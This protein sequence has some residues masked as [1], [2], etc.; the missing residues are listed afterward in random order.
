MPEIVGR[1]AE[2]AALTGFVDAVGKGPCALVFAGE[3]GIGKTT[4]WSAGVALAQERSFQVLSCRSAE[5]EAKLSYAGLGDVLAEVA[6][7][8]LG[9]LPDLQRHAVEVALLRT[10]PGE[11]PVD[12]RTVAAGTLGALRLLA[13]T[14]PVVM[15]LD[16]PQWMDAAS[17]QALKYAVRRLDDEP[18]GVLAAVR[19]GQGLDDPLEISR[20]FSD[21]RLQQLEIG[22]LSLEALERMLDQRLGWV[23]TGSALFELHTVSEGNPLFALE[24]ARA[25]M[26]Q[27]ERSLVV[28][29]SLREQASG[30]LAALPAGTRE[31]LVVAAALPRPTLGMI[32]QVIG[33]DR[34]ALEPAAEAGMLEVQGDTVRFTH[35]L[36]ASVAYA[37]AGKGDRVRIHRRLSELLTDPEERARHLAL[38][39]DPPDV[40]VA[41]ALEEAANRAR[42]RGA[43]MV[44]AALRMEARTFTPEDRADDGR[45]RAVLAA[46]DLYVVGD[47]TRTKVLLE[48]ALAECPDGS[49]RARVLWRLGRL[50]CWGDVMSLDATDEWLDLAE[51]H[52]GDDP[53]L[54]SQIHR[55]RCF[56]AWQRVRYSE[57]PEHARV[58]LEMAERAGDPVGIAASLAM[59]AAAEATTGRAVVDDLIVRA[60]EAWAEAARAPRDSVIVSEDHPALMCGT[61]YLWTGRLDEARSMFQILE[62]DSRERGSEVGLC[63]ALS[64]LF[65]VELLAGNWELAARYVD[66]ELRQAKYVNEIEAVLSR[67]SLSAHLGR[68]D[69]ARRDLMRVL[70]YNET[71]GSIDVL[72]EVLSRLGFLELSLGNLA[73]THGYLSRATEVFMEAGICEPGVV[74]EVHF[75]PDEIEALVGLGE[76]AEAERLIDWLEERG[77]ALDRVWALAVGSRCRG[78]LFAAKGD[79]E[80]AVEHIERAMAEHERLPMPFERARTLLVL[81]SVRRRADH[82]RAAREALTEALEVFERLGAVLW[83]E[84]ARAELAAIGGRAPGIG[85]FT[86]MEERVARLAAAGRTNREIAETLFLSVRTVEHH[87]SH[88]YAKRGV[89]S[90]TEL[91]LV[92]DD[93]SVPTP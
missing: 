73:A 31:T 80:V 49:E 39:V 92:L 41:A 46:D 76:L 81:G 43:P 54:S 90:R 4:L 78:L 66:E 40:G 64:W 37:D 55:M 47:H 51:E 33:R 42:S 48:Q 3:P 23:A 20:A 53:W 82:K 87:L 26:E 16:D 25:S 15:A 32:E 29:R 93:D 27:P 86:P 77:R 63:W 22:P 35:P 17:R 14:G 62:R 13:S 36:Y 74:H 75:L 44:A 72:H 60:T 70:A 28:P 69:E 68:V 89:R 61:A 88:A 34:D 19:V 56:L 11:M 21:G 50:A 6:D 5:S 67:G 84:K 71:G 7:E 30:R 83:A 59:M 10:E 12:H 52:A 45:R 38:S 1:E 18:I 57:L 91:T 58:A 79:Q 65:E 8:A 2:L 24:I 9:S 85:E